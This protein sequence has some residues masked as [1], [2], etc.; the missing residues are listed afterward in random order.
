MN[1]IF[2]ENLKKIYETFGREQLIP[3]KKVAD[4]LGVYDRSLLEDKSFPTKKIM[5]RHYVGAVALARW[6]S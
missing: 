1:E 4:Y 6:L 2:E 5:S 3:V